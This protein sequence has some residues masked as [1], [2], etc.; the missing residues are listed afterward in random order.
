MSEPVNEDTEGQ[1]T[2]E[3]REDHKIIASLSTPVADYDFRRG[4][5]IE[6]VKDEPDD[7][8]RPFTIRI[9]DDGGKIQVRN[10]EGGKQVLHAR[11][12]LDNL[13]NVNTT[14][15]L[16][17]LNFDDSYKQ[18]YSDGRIYSIPH[19]LK[20]HLNP[21]T[22]M[23]EMHGGKVTGFAIKIK[24]SVDDSSSSASGS[25]IT[26]TEI[27]EDGNDVVIEEE[28]IEQIEEVEEG[29]I[30]DSDAVEESVIGEEEIEQKQNI[31]LPN[32]PEKLELDDVSS[33]EGEE[34]E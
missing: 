5:S 25:K 3:D 17:S 34:G 16:F 1:C 30:K 19:N 24:R 4:F 11:I 18:V 22:C 27:D 8:S 15:P 26:R 33:E 12:N 31:K 32:I 7:E 23:L 28:I 10:E 6:S 21:P 9:G 2:N 20:H 13:L 14:D 29:E